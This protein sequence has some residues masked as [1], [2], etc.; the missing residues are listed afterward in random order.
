M[1]AN[2]LEGA[3]AGAVAAPAEVVPENKEENVFAGSEA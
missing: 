2:G 1:L 3:T